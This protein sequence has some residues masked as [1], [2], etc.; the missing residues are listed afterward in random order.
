MR[1]AGVTAER[2][3]PVDGPSSSP[4][5]VFIPNGTGRRDR[6]HATTVPAS[7]RPDRRDADARNNGV[8]SAAARP[9]D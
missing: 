6:G 9:V 8:V 3:W 2:P 5:V 1:P 7:Q 4:A